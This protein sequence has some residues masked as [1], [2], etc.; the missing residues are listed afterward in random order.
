MKNLLFKFIIFQDDNI[1]EETR[2]F[3]TEVAENFSWSWFGMENE[4]KI[5][6]FLMRN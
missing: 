3:W 5:S 6:E 2:G 1:L 4:D